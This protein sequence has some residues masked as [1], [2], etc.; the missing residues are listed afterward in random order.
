[1]TET[2]QQLRESHQFRIE[3]IEGWSWEILELKGPGVPIVFLAGGQGTC[4]VFYKPMLR[5]AGQR[6]MLGMHYPANPDAAEIADHLALLL[7]RLGL[8]VIAI[9]GTS[10][11]SYVAQFFAAKYPERVDQLI[12]GNGFVSAEEVKHLPVFDKAVL[13]TYCPADFK[14]ERVEALQ[15]QPA[16]EYREVM[17]DLIGER[18]SAESVFA[19]MMGVAIS[20]P[21]PEVA[22]GMDRITIID[23]KDDTVITPE[24]K[25]AVTER[26]DGA[27]LRV[28]A[29]GGHFPSILAADDYT[30]ILHEKLI[31]GSSDDR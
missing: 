18:Q 7:D 17:L 20:I 27:D 11:G 2:L 4:E 8:D 14:R 29:S 26:F 28:M 30:A 24:M 16:S 13:E 10:F 23:C 22:V 31:G 19:R 21:A 15:A 5:M 1:M 6:S 25:Q 12:L 9:V 3:T